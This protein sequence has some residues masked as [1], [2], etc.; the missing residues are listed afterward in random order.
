MTEISKRKVPL[1]GGQARRTV[2][3]YESAVKH[4]PAAGIILRQGA[5][6]VRDS[7]RP[8]AHS[9]KGLSGSGAS[10]AAML[11]YTRPKPRYAVGR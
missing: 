11:K 1:P 9:V 4:W 5:R 3:T 2:A 10:L 8:T 7:E 6:V